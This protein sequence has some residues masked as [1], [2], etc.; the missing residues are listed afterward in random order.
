[1]LNRPKIICHMTT[2]INGKVTG[3]FLENEKAIDGINQ[4]YEINRKHHSSFL[5]GRKTM[6]ESFTKCFYPNLEEFKNSYVPEG[7]FITEIDSFAFAIAIDPL[8]KLGW[9]KNKIED[10]DS[11]YNNKVVIEVLS[12]QAPKEYLA[13][14][15]SINL[16]YIICGDNK[17]DLKL[18]LKKLRYSFN[19]QKILLEG[20]SITNSTFLKQDLIDELSL[21][22]VPIIASSDSMSLFNESSISN[23]KLDKT[24]SIKDVVILNYYNKN[25]IYAENLNFKNFS[26]TLEYLK[27][28]ENNSNLIQISF[29]ESFN[30]IKPNQSKINYEK[31]INSTNDFKYIKCEKELINPFFLKFLPELLE[32]DK[33]ILNDIFNKKSIAILDKKNQCVNI[34]KTKYMNKFE[35]ENFYIYNIIEYLKM[36]I[37]NINFSTPNTKKQKELFNTLKENNMCLDDIF[38]DKIYFPSQ[39]LNE[40]SDSLLSFIFV[41]LLLRLERFNKINNNE[42]PKL[43]KEFETI[44]LQDLLNNFYYEMKN[45]KE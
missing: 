22:V 2:S 23:Y 39:L 28:M 44:L 25:N 42:T 4:Y 45:I 27:N 8:G 41:K 9:K 24:E 11:G 29:Q 21:V 16:P 13:Y 5:C 20:G 3:S 18:A 6:E 30:I 17:I 37:S 38:I 12:K 35:G 43:I 19:I 36:Y 33:E 26:K 40:N 14:L 7:D 1:M 15:R 10:E 32:I 34:V 31:Q